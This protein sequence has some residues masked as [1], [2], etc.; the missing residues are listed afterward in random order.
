MKRQSRLAVTSMR[1]HLLLVFCLLFGMVML[2]INAVS[3][4]ARTIYVEAEKEAVENLSLKVDDEV[5]GRISVIGDS[6]DDIDF[7][8]TDPG[9]NVVV[10]HEKVSV[11]DFRF[12]AS[13]EG[14]Y[15]LHFDNTFSTE[16]KTVT[17]N[18]DV[19]HY[20]FGIPQ[21]DFLVFM[22]MI[23]GMIGLVL[24]VAVSRP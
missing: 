13:R 20:I 3:A 16:R 24:F 18:Y 21:E 1:L 23:V 22:V 15:T 7:F 12:K 4:V 5:S 17:F 11:Q 2:S 14:T 10:Q 6:S 9:E 8:I 19:R